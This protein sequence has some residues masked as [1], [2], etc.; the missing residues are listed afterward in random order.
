MKHAQVVGQSLG[1]DVD[2]DDGYVELDNT[3]MVSTKQHVLETKPGQI[4]QRSISGE[5]L[6]V[7]CQTEQQCF[8]F[9]CLDEVGWAEKQNTLPT[10]NHQKVTTC[11][12]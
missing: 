2:H 8:Q 1:V 6:H 12:M 7:G 4:F 10:R 11:M 9:L 3:T 5:L